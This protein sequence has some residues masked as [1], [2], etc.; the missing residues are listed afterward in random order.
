[1]ASNFVINTIAYTGTPLTA[2]TPMKPTAY[3]FTDQKIGKTVVNANGGRT[4]I[5]R[6]VQKKTFSI[7]WNPCNETTRAALRTLA[8]LTTVFNFTDQLGTVYVCQVESDDYSEEWVY[9][10]VANVAWYVC[11]ITLRQA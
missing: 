8:E 1:M 7:E 2:G 6:S 3:S 5:A 10:D 9:S 4:F 11:K